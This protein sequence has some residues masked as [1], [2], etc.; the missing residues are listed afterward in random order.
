M[1]NR[2]W[3][4]TAFRGMKE[5][6]RR[7]LRAAYPGPQGPSAEDAGARESAVSGLVRITLVGP[8][9]ATGPGDQD[10]L[11]R[12]RRARAILA[13]L[14]LARGGKI[15]RSRLYGQ[16]WDRA[17]EKQAKASFRQA[18]FEL[19]AAFGPHADL[20]V[21]DRDDIRLDVSGCWIDALAFRQDLHAIPESNLAMMVE[22]RFLQELDG[23]S[24]S[25][26]QWLSGERHR[27]FDELRLLHEA[28]M[29]RLGASHA[30]P[31]DVA[32]AARRLI[33]IDPTNEIACRTKMLALAQMGNRAKALQTFQRCRE[34][35]ATLLD[36][37]PSPQTVAV[38]QAIR[39][40]GARGSKRPDPEAASSS[41][42]GA[43][44]TRREHPL[45]RGT[46]EQRRMRLGVLTPTLTSA[47][48]DESVPAVLAQELAGALSRRR[49]FDVFALGS[50]NRSGAGQNPEV[51][52][53]LD[54]TLTLSGGQLQVSVQLVSVEEGLRPLWSEH[55][56]TSRIAPSEIHKEVT[57]K[58][59]GRLGPI[60]TFVEGRR[61][62]ENNQQTSIAL[63]LQAIPLF[64][65]LEREKFEQ[66]GQL[67][68]R[69]IAADSGNAMAVAW[70]AFWHVYHFGQGWTHDA[71]AAYVKAEEMCV[72]AMRLD[73]ENAEALGIYGHISAYLRHD[74]DNA[75]YHFDRS[76]RLDPNSAFVWAMSAAS[77]C[78][79]GAPGVAIERMDRYRELA[80]FDP[81]FPL[82]ETV[83]A[84]AHNLS[85]DHA[86]A[87]IVARRVVAANPSFRNGYKHLIAALGHLGRRD[88]ALR[89]V[90]KLFSI[91][92][93]FSIAQFEQTYPLRRREDRERYAKGLRLAGIPS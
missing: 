40:E 22:G 82:W 13:V 66:A 88:E 50:N 52:Y 93:D 25:F 57:A 28:E 23:T 56:E 55:F 14:C 20:I 58:V 75:V 67:L 47:D 32:A 68:D 36:A 16:I 90:E 64:Y 77:H 79:L 72:R 45:L 76:L 80:P 11:P 27:F 24:P 7:A 89:H 54:G 63:W 92:P 59:V 49:W 37:A 15:P 73:P 51:D 9:Q 85:G 5:R 83:Y 48:L 70:S 21:T 91:E 62:A 3:G 69:A 53:L 4:V 78:Y 39:A 30:P 19:S 74:L 8:M 38:Y 31:E 12:S 41:S 65:T 81:Y 34:A 17:G 43:P 60:L 6:S 33:A 26:D 46:Q 44:L 1:T 61:A 2:I 29:Q 84:V 10:L 18:L 42:P 86:R 87:A 35:L 71:Q